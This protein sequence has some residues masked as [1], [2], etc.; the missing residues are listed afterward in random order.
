MLLALAVLATAAACAVDS[1]TGE[2][3][4]L[5]P[6]L[7]FA[8]LGAAVGLTTL[9]AGPVPDRA[10]AAGGRRC[11][12]VSGGGTRSPRIPWP[13]ADAPAPAE[14]RST[15]VEVARQGVSRAPATL[16]RLVPALPPSPAPPHG[17]PG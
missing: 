3:G 15:L 10:T 11:D 5:G 2:G 16:A 6:F 9:C 12:E 14:A 7:A 4:G 8:A 1:A 13:G 17:A